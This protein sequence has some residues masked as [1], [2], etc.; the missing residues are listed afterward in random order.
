MAFDQI[1]TGW[2]KIRNMMDDGLGKVKKKKLMETRPND[3]L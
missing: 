1:M 2:R 3:S